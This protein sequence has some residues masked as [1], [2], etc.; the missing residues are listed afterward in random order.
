MRSDDGIRRRSRASRVRWLA[1]LA[2]PL[3]LG[4]ARAEDSLAQVKVAFLFNFALYTSWEKIDN[5][6]DVCLVGDDRL[7]AD[8]Q[9][10]ARREI[11]GRPVRVRRLGDAP[12]WP[13]QECDLVY[14]APGERGRIDRLLSPLAGKPILTI[15]DLGDAAGD[16][17]SGAMIRMYEVGERIRFDADL[18][19]VEQAGLRLSAK[20][21]RLASDVRRAD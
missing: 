4:S 13:E 15:A 14:V 16:R 2:L 8:V 1:L 9:A 18:N 7:G 21:L 12:K 6:F 5:G 11:A 10:L 3:M 17:P 20:L 19:L